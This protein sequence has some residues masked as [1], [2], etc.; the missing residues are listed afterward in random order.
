[1]ETALAFYCEKLGFKK[2]SEYRP[3]DGPEPA[4][5]VIQHGE[6]GLHLSSFSGDGQTGGRA[7][8]YCEDVNALH[9]ELGERGVDV[10]PEPMDQSWG[11]REMYISD[12][13]GNQ[14]RYT[15]PGKK[16]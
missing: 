6:T 4:Y 10:G 16:S 13:D 8:V 11:D 3:H 5:V 7:V 2:R 14:L 9:R 15:Q 12:P 1:M